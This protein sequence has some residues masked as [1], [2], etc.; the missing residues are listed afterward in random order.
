MRDLG[1]ILLSVVVSCGA[2]VAAATMPDPPSRPAKSDTAFLRTVH[3]KEHA[4]AAA[5]DLMAARASRADIRAAALRMARDQARTIDDVR[6][7]AFRKSVALADRFELEKPA[8]RT[9]TGPLE[10]LS[11]SALENAWV[12]M[13][14]SDHQAA[15]ARFEDASK[16]EDR[17]VKRFVDRTLPVLRAHLKLAREL[18][19]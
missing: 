14:I 6:D 11:A 10:T 1:P 15:I 5:A 18:T 2:F 8:E 12:K 7:L 16:S 13:T 4:E 3:E 17:D 19:R 9:G